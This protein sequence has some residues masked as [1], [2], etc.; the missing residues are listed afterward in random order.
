MSQTFP[1]IINLF[2]AI[3]G[4]LGQ[5]CYK[6]GAQKLKLVPLLLNWQIWLGAL[7][8]TLVMVMFIWSF[9]LGGRISI[10]FPAYATTFIWGTILGVLFDKE[11]FNWIQALGILLVVVGISLVAS[12]GS[13]KTA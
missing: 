9:K 1:I 6:L 12:F 2:A 13:I 8:F 10:T 5:Y 4:A 7:L 3:V 11:S